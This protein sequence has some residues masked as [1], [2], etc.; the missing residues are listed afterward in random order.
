MSPLSAAWPASFFGTVMAALAITATASG[1]PVA[2]AK[3]QPVKGFADTHLHQMAD[4]AWGGGF[5]WGKHDGPQS[6]ALPVCS[7]GNDHGFLLG[8]GTFGFHGKRRDGYPTFNGWPRWDAVSHQTVHADWL[9][10]AHQRGLSLVVM[11]AGN[12]EPFCDVIP[13]KFRKWECNDMAAVDRMVDAAHN[14]ARV[15]PWYEIART[16]GDARRIINQGKLAVVLSIEVGELFGK[17]D[18]EASLDRYYKKGVRTMG[19]THLLNSRFSATA[20]MPRDSRVIELIERV[21]SGKVAYPIKRSES[22]FN[23]DGLTADGKKLVRAMMARKMLVD[24]AHMSRRAF[25]DTFDLARENRFYPVY[26]SHGY[27]KEIMV[28]EKQEG[29]ERLSPASLVARIKKTGGVFGLRTGAEEMLTYR[30]SGVANNCHGSSRSFAQQY[31]LAAIGLKVPVAFGSDL[32]GL[33]A[34][35]APR[36]GDPKEA[37][38]GAY[39]FEREAQQRAQGKAATQGLGSEFDTK[40]FA[41]V[42]LM[43]DVVADLKRLGVDTANIEN[44]AEAFIAMWERAYDEKRGA[45]PDDVDVSGVAPYEDKK[46]RRKASRNDE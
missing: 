34:Q 36:F 32:N 45:L 30:K 18:W 5:I 15:H 25:D 13:K 37:C 23:A 7:G 12:D 21:Q 17:R 19:L 4:L 1:A 20:V 29:D 11:S 38:E 41:R 43:A 10:R 8:E 35:M 39:D 9:K 6:K 27:L 28:P 16:P 2:P 14:F 22:G 44:S 40:G 26:R 33:I 46:V 42:D 31:Q 24:T 3:S